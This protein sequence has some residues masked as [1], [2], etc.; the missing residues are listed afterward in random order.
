MKDEEYRQPLQAG[1]PLYLYT[2][3]EHDLVQMQWIYTIG[4]KR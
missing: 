4:S 3:N 1:G 2:W